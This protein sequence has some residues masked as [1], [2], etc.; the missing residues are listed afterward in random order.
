MFP[1]A[2]LRAGGRNIGRHV[3]T[4]HLHTTETPRTAPPRRLRF[5]RVAITCVF[6]DPADPRTWSGAPYNL[7]AALRRLGVEVE[8]IHPAMARARRL[9]YAARWLLDGYG[10]LSTTEQVLRAAPARDHNALK[11]AEAT[12]RLGVRH[13]IHT[14]TLDLPAFDLLPDIRHYLYC[15]QS[16]NLSLRHRLDAA[17]YT[18][19]ALAEYDRL[20]RDSLASVAHVFTFSARTRDDIVGHYGVPPERVTVVGSGMGNIP[21][22]FGPKDYRAARLLFVAKHLFRA[23]GGPLLLRA[24]ALARR[25]RPDMSLTIVGD[26][27]SRAYVPRDPRIAFLAHVNWDTLRRLYADSTL[28]AQPMLNDPWGQ[29]YLEALASRTPVLGFNRNGLPEITENGRHGFL[30][31]DATPEAVAAAILI[32]LSDPERLRRMGESGQRHV[33]NAY[34]WDRVGERIACL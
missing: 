6:G 9:A 17:H 24:F 7:A 22:Y 31:D 8:T 15:D 28:L 2:P 21:P 1:Q 13:V 23:K 26:A 30:V 29:V 5:D 14:G 3:S 32:A 18:P 4:V 16:W 27:R 33:M 10:R 25:S 19:R 20:E 12:A 34:S 11:V